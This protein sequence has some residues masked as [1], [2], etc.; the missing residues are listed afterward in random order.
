MLRE[1]SCKMTRVVL[2]PWFP[3]GVDTALRT[4]PGISL[5]VAVD[6]DDVASAMHAGAEIL[7]TSFWRDDYLSPSLKWIAST[8]AG[9]EQYPHALLAE[10]SVVLTTAHG[11]HASCVA[12]HAF[13]LLLACVR[14]IG[15]AVRDMGQHEWTPR[16]GEELAGKNMLV[17]GLGL[18][19][20]EV[21]RRAL[22]WDMD[23]R[24]VKRTPAGYAGTVE[25]VAGPEE[26]HQMLEWADVVVIAAPSTPETRG[27]MGPRELELLGSG[28]LVNVARGDLVDATALHAALVDGKL[29]GAG[30]DVT[31]PEPLPNE[32][33]L[34]DLP[35]VV[36]SA[37]MAGNS[38]SFGPRW[39][40]IFD[41]NL[42]AMR[43]SSA[44]TNR[45]DLGGSK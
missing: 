6:R 30:L 32:S 14:H 10:K 11:V 35:Q 34:W 3:P 5:H 42:E 41:S 4:V 25:H 44:W 2:H 1:K 24:A 33:P 15:A 22:A 26:L 40:K 19:G 21:A 31:V 17:V 12:E 29:R 36:L 45:V 13:A 38:P 43:G 20:E 37:H 9:T 23:V 39:L 28:W 7:V 16:V 18:I 27:L 8:G